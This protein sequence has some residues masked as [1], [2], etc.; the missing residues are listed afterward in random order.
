MPV[1]PSPSRE[2]RRRRRHE[3]RTLTYVTLDHAN[4]GVVRNLTHDGI[5]VHAVTAVRPR[6]QLRV[7]FELR[8]PRLR[9]DTRGE[10]V[11]ST[12]S[13]RCGIRFLELPAQT[14]RLI[15]EWIFGNMLE[16]LSLPTD[17]ERPIFAA[18]AAATSAA[19][20]APPPPIRAPEAP[21]PALPPRN[22]YVAPAA[23]VEARAA[24]AFVPVPVSEPAA[25]VE[26]D[27]HSFPVELDWLFQ[28]L[29]GRRLAWTV[30]SLV[31]FAAL[32]LF[33]IIF[34]SIAG[35]APKWPATMVSGAAIVV[36]G[37]YWVFFK[38]FGGA[39]LGVRLARLA[40][41]TSEDE[42]PEDDRFR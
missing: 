20:L 31:V 22:T 4:G 13:G 40:E 34:L 6:Q 35:E 7:R 30:N 16:G 25:P 19:V 39:S 24:A 2:Q 38:M 36:A 10:V 9:I 11:W 14:V 15:D 8:Y 18:A 32:L 5:T 42:D 3:L 33:V 23:R 29:S 28:P 21:K 1:A 12:F 26:Q 17:K 37:L 27:S 41:I